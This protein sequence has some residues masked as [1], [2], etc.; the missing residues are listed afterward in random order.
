MPAAGLVDS[1]KFRRS[2]SPQIMII[3]ALSLKKLV[4]DLVQVQSLL[5]N[6][7]RTV[8]QLGEQQQRILTP[9]QGLP[10]EV[11]H[12]E[13]E[14]N[15]EIWQIWGWFDGVCVGQGDDGHEA[16]PED[17]CF[18][19]FELGEEEAVEPLDADHFEVL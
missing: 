12:C 10:V 11:H 5:Q 2:I 4:V 17:E 14:R 19:N 16:V 8:R 6:A 13:G 9:R 15:E 7:L 18:V 1:L 3:I